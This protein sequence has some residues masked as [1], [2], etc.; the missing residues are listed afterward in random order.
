MSAERFRQIEELYHA[1][2]ERSREER[3]ALLSRADPDLRREVES[4]LAQDVSG[5]P[6]ER[7]AMEAAA[8]LLEETTATELSSGAQLGPYR[9]DALLGAGGMGRVYKAR[10]TRL[11]R[12]V[13]IKICHEEFSERFQREARAIAALNHSHI[14]TLHDIGPNYLVMEHVEGKPLKGPLPLDKVLEYGSQICDAL[15]AAHRKGIVHR[16][17]K[18]SN[19]L[20]TRS[21]V[22]VLDFGLAKMS[23][24]ETVTQAGAM[25]GTPAYMAPEQREGKEVDLRADIYSLGCVLYEM[26]TGERAPHR[27]LEPPALDR[28]VKTC[29]ATDPEERWQ[30]A[31]EVRLALEFAGQAAAKA[32]GHKSS[33]RWAWGVAA[34]ACAGLLAV[35]TAVLSRNSARAP[36][37]VYRAS[38]LPPSKASPNWNRTGSFALSPDGRRIVLAAGG[39]LWV[40][41]LDQDWTQPLAGTEGGEAPF[42]SPDSRKLGF[43]AQGKLKKIDL[44]GGPPITLADAQGVAGGSWNRDDV[45]LFASNRSPLKR[46][47][48]S[49]GSSAAVTTLDMASGET[50]HE[51]PSFLPDGVHFLYLSVGTTSGSPSDPRGICLGS[52]TSR[53]PNMILEGGAN[54]QYA[55]GHLLFVRQGA[56]MA[57]QFDIKRF[58]LAG[59]PVTLAAQIHTDS[60]VRGQQAGDFSVSQAGVLAYQAGSESGSRLVWFDRGGRQLG[61]LGDEAEYGPPALSPD[62]RRSAVTVADRVNGTRDI[63]IF[64]LARGLRTRLTSG[65][66]DVRGGLAWSPDGSRIAFRSAHEGGFDVY[67][68]TSIGTGELRPLWKDSLSKYP[69]SWSLDGRFILYFTGM[70]T[71]RTL[72]DLW[73]LPLLGD[74]KPF[75]FLQSTFNEMS[76]EFSS[77]GRWVVYQSNESGPF[78]VYVAPFPGPGGKVQV[79]TAGGVDPRWTKDGREILYEASDRKLMAAAVDGRAS[80][81]EVGAVR[82][83]FE[84][85]TQVRGWDATADGQRFLVNTVAEETD[86]SIT[87]VVN[88]A[89]SL[90]R[91]R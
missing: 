55:Q 25:I 56:L 62:G 39:R 61:V 12:W 44:S 36:E 20:L 19:I 52:L 72:S 41:T 34:L 85:H 23:G 35:S 64:D 59:E 58:E 15:D 8:N 47:S 29:V 86:R 70:T 28:V 57:R 63:W 53:E 14:C 45:I 21:G 7:P 11:D 38:I 49:G 40:R 66:R 37:H 5:G 51:W 87:L 90:S 54:A 10:D 68:T 81:F 78:E 76:G 2:R 71:P 9:L 50:R 75:P 22:K 43:F 46:V 18:P 26:A 1:A 84:M 32:P 60:V 73:I 82:P 31:R 24:Q 13:A 17:L 27:T 65:A 69:T 16:D 74:R 77:D 83:V 88:W 3:I 4:L 30:S 67:Q 42:W 91:P 48:A 89:A 80:R 79:S 6:L 33:A